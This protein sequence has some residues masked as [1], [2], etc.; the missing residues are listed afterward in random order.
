MVVAQARHKKKPVKRRLEA[1]QV[2]RVPTSGSATPAT[3]GSSCHGRDRAFC[4]LLAEAG[5]LGPVGRGIS[6][7]LAVTFGVGRFALAHHVLALGGR[8]LICGKIEVERARAI[9]GVALG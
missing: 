7:A 3:S 6:R 8:A 9:W 4:A 2:G 1:R 5:A